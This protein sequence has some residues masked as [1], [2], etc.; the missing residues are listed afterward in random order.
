MLLTIDIGNTETV[1]GLFRG[2]K[3]LTHFRIS[4][5]VPR[6]PDEVWMMLTG[7]FENQSV[8]PGILKSAVI[9]SVVPDLTTVFEEAL[10]RNLK[11]QPLIVTSAISAG[12]EIRYDDPKTVGADRICNG[13]AGFR[14]YGGPLIV[15]DFGTATTLDVISETGTY[16][17]GVITLGLTGASLE[18]H[19]I[20]AKLPMVALS[21][22]D[23]IVGHSTET[24]MQSGILW[25]TVMMVDGLVEKIREEMGWKHCQVV[26]TGGMAPVLAG[27]S[28]C[29]QHMD[30]FLTLEGML[31]IYK[32]FEKNNK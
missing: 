3:L 32:H 25:G 8:K 11:L 22:P 1:M 15:V 17:G 28:A 5:K 20:S 18:L 9:S 23:R 31:N 26:A 24:S 2:D 30:I 6:T 27:K 29:I 16:L 14:K 12:M 13:V 10:F 7:W 4:S 19:R 21:F